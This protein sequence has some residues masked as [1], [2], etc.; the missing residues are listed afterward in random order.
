MAVQQFLL[1]GKEYNVDVVALTRKFSVLDTDLSG[2]T[3]DGEMYRDIIGTFYNYTMTVQQRGD[4]AASL[5]AFWE[6]VSQPVASHVCVFPYNQTTLSQKMYVTSGEQ[7]I[8]RKL[9]K[10]T[11]WKELTINFI[12]TK[13]QVTP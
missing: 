10:K 6:A 9:A 5:D 8:R 1:D 13:P 7:E 2:R 4:D 12:A 11:D 3:Q